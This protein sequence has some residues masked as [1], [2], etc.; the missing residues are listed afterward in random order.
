MIP[1]VKFRVDEIAQVYE[2]T[3]WVNTF[4]GKGPDEEE[5]L[6]VETEMIPLLQ[7]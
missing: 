3:M 5:G 2:W 4:P 7:L 1:I 6:W